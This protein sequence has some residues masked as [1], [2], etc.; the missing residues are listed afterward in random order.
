MHC[1]SIICNTYNHVKYIKEALDSFLMQDVS[2]PFEILVHD[3]ASTDGTDDVIRKYE[4]KYPNIIKPLYQKENQYSRGIKITPQIQL[5]RTEGKFVAFCEG[6]DYWTDPNKLQRQYEFME[7]HPEYS[8][9]CHAYDMVAKDRQ[10][11][12]SQSLMLK[13]GVVPMSFLIGNQIYAPHFATLFI[14]RKCLVNLGPEF[15]G[16]SC[17]DMTLRLYCAAQ[18]PLFYLAHDMSAYRRFTEG[19]WTMRIGM[20]QNLI[21]KGHEENICFLRQYDAYTH[22]MYSKDI[23]ECIDWREF[24]IALANGDFRSAQEKK[25]YQ[26]A[27]FK[28]KFY[29]TLGCMFPKLIQKLRTT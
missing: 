23:E 9:C 26:K 1:I 17:N 13:D 6:D 29:I 8:G 5:P 27:S 28:R 24:E 18:A 16:K 19:S 22:G 15:L 10:L 3:D 21:R 4:K 14:R 11:I 25:A 12:K 7:N 20:N 2:V